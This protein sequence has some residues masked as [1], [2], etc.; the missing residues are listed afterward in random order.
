MYIRN[1][2]VYLQIQYYLWYMDYLINAASSHPF[3]FTIYQY[4]VT[5]N[6][7]T[8]RQQFGS[9]ILHAKLI[10]ET[11]LLCKK[12]NYVVLTEKFNMKHYILVNNL[13]ILCVE[14]DSKIKSGDYNFR[15]DSN[16][17]RVFNSI[18]YFPLKIQYSFL[19]SC[20][21]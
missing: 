5:F 12:K 4:A 13:Y 20:Q 10:Q 3:K 21:V 7:H 1:I 8:I 14:I 18:L 6:N 9:N 15:I 2:S 11:Y 19:N 17:S 16:Y